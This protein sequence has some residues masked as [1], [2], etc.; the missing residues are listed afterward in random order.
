MSL[1]KISI[2]SSIKLPSVPFLSLNMIPIG[3]S[4]RMM[5]WIFGEAPSAMD[6]L[7]STVLTIGKVNKCVKKAMNVK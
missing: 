4:M 7:H 2:F 3:V 1:M 6:M 5:Q